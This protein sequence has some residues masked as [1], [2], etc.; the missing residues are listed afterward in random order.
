MLI[1]RDFI[2]FKTD[3]WRNYDIWPNVQKGKNK[4]KKGEKEY[5]KVNYLLYFL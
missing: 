5:A 1:R 2:E 3:L 4:S